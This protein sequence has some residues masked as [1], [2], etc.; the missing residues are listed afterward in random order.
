MT[1]SQEAFWKEP[2]S[3]KTTARTASCSGA[4]TLNQR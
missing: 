4:K 1:L 2:K 3:Q